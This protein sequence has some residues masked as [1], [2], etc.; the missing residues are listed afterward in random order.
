MQNTDDIYPILMDKIKN[1]VGTLREA[2]KSLVDV[3][4]VFTYMWPVNQPGKA[5][6]KSTQIAIALLFS[7]FVHGIAADIFQIAVGA[8]RDPI[9]LGH[10]ERSKFVMMFSME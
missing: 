2:V 3:W 1:Q 4:T 7:P 8:G 6:I 5:L 10:S 9:S